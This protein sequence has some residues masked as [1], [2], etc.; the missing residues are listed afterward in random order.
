MKEGCFEF[1]L[2]VISLILSWFLFVFFFPLFWLSLLPSVYF[3][4][5][6]VTN[7]ILA[8]QERRS[9]DQCHYTES[10]RNQVVLT[11]LRRATQ[12]EVQVRARTMA[13]YG[14]FSPTAIFSTLPDGKKAFTHFLFFH[15]AFFHWQKVFKRPCTVFWSELAACVC[16]CNELV[17]LQTAFFLQSPVTYFCLFLRFLTRFA[18]TNPLC[19]FW[20]YINSVSVS[21][22]HICLFLRAWLAL[23]ACGHWH[24]Y[25]RR[26]AAARHFCLCGCLLYTVRTR[27]GKKGKKL[28]QKNRKWKKKE[29]NRRDEH[30]KQLWPQFYSFA[31]LCSFCLYKSYLICV[32]FA[33][34]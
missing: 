18:D 23:S 10:N 25:R 17:S 15:C 13:G 3:S 20:D 14:S 7:F 6:S 1:L 31:L 16:P 2:N 8:W 5:C 30:Q 12:Y 22:F 32:G 24:P 21:L 28:C 27:E 34:C 9:K 26:T 4:H 11:D 19:D 29:G 33:L